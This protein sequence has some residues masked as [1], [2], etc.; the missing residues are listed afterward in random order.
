MGRF[1]DDYEVMTRK[2]MEEYSK[3]SNAI[4][5]YIQFL[6]VERKVS[7]EQIRNI[8]KEI[9]LTVLVQNDG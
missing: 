8:L 3:L 5:D 9:T 1:M 4:A 2:N 6:K 7:R